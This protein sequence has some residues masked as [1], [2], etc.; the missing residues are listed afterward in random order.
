M[1][2]KEAA[3]IWLKPSELKPWADNPRKND[4]EPTAKVAESIKRFGFGAPIIARR[5]NKEIIAGHTRWKAAQLLKLD[6][7]PVR[8]L[9]ITEREAHLL[10]LAD[11]RLTELTEWSETLGSVLSQYDLQEAEMAGWDQDDLDAMASEL[12]GSEQ[13]V[14][15]DEAPEVPVKAITQLGDIWTLGRHQLFVLIQQH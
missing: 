4:G 3:A 12:A 9:D 8:L 10:A 6:R 5:E 15:E 1:S 14:E 13:A 7:V 11:N 2:D